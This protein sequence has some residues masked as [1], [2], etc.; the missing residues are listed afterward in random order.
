[1]DSRPDLRA[2]S[3]GV[4]GVGIGCSRRRRTVICAGTRR[5]MSEIEYPELLLE[6]ARRYCCGIGLM[7]HSD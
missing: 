6:A 5:G 4:T 3:F 1:M 2:G 7:G